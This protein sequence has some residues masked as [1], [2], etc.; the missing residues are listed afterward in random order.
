MK[1]G[2]ES[3]SKPAACREIYK[4]QWS[5]LYVVSIY[6]KVMDWSRGPPPA[7]DCCCVLWLLCMQRLSPALSLTLAPSSHLNSSPHLSLSLL[8]FSGSFSLPVSC[9]LFDPPLVFHSACDTFSSFP[10]DTFL[11]F[12]D[13]LPSE[14]LWHSRKQPRSSA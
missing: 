4:D 1:P 8:F 2:L 13:S 6:A 11:C 14:K 10:R 3:Q 12:S 5:V 9:L 7:G